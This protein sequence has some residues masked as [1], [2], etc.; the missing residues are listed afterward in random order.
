MSALA[1]NGVPKE[2]PKNMRLVVFSRTLFVDSRAVSRFR[3]DTKCAWREI[4]Y[5]DMHES[6]RA[7]PSKCRPNRKDSSIPPPM[8]GLA[9]TGKSE[10]AR[11]AQNRASLGIRHPHLEIVGSQVGHR[12]ALRIE[13]ERVQCNTS[14]CC[15]GLLRAQ[16]R[17]GEKGK[18]K[19][20][21]ADQGSSGLSWIR[22]GSLMS[23]S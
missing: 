20:D 23:L 8:G 17:S 22:V 18:S 9:V 15:V 19:A 11:T 13:G 7:G 4:E 14:G 6:I 16:T 1:A 2:S 12:I 5:R 21:E 10:L 3:T